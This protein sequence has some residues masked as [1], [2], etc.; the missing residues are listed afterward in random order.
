MFKGFQYKNANI[1]PDQTAQMA[2]HAAIPVTK[3]HLKRLKV[4]K[5]YNVIIIQL[6]V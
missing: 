5:Y 6:Y 1:E 2:W 4:K 3:V